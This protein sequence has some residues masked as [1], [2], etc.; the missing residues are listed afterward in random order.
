VSK[1]VLVGLGA[2]C[3][4]VGGSASAQ[5]LQRSLSRVEL[6]PF[7]GLQFGGGFTTAGGRTV[8]LDAGLDYGGMLDIRVGQTWFLEGMYSRQST[9]LGADGGPFEVTVER[10]MGGLQEERGDGPTKYFGVVLLGATKFTPKVGGFT[11]ASRFTV[12]LGL[13]FKH[14][15]SEHLGLRGEI[16]GYYV[17]AETG[18]G[19]F[20]A[21]SCLFVFSGSGLWQGDLAG[22]LVFA[23]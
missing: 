14:L 12:G 15:F 2:A 21:G 16:R 1:L 19:I 23:F 3:V 6:A 17:T 11:S 8:S 4:L 10:L 9:S 5:P 7:A 20:C 13:G 22:G 18:G